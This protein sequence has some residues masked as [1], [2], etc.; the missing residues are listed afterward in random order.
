MYMPL[1]MR[2][3]YYTTRA[4]EKW[5]GYDEVQLNGSVSNVVYNNYDTPNVRKANPMKHWR[6]QYSSGS[7]M[8]SKLISEIN[9]PG[10]TTVSSVNR[11]PEKSPLQLDY[12]LSKDR[13]CCNN[14]QN[15]A[16]QLTRH[17][18][19]GINEN[20][21]Y[22]NNSLTK[23]DCLSCDN[24][25][26]YYHHSSSYLERKKQRVFK[27]ES[28]SNILEHVDCCD[29]AEQITDPDEK[30]FQIHGYNRSLT[31]NDKCKC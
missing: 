6:R 21:K 25:M 17:Y 14:E 19:K 18:T 13:G 3:M 24:S 28:S 1:N 31:I 9:K 29:L 30:Y 11:C 15:K 10:G 26:R 27:K 5:K 2:S 4:S 16:L 22:G 20:I 7:A 12:R 23:T 8:R